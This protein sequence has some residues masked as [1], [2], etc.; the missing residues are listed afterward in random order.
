MAATSTTNNSVKAFVARLGRDYPDF[1][2]TA[3]QQEHWSPKTQTITFN[4]SQPVQKLKFGLLHELAHAL[5]GH[6]NY[7]SDF[8]LLKLESRAW[9]LAAKIGKKYN[10]HIDDAH[11]QRCLNTYRDWL[12]ARSAC[13]A[14]GVHSLQQ[15]AHTY[16][17][18][19]CQTNWRVSS[20]RF[21]RAYRKT[22]K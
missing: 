6:E 8:E 22:I 19:N 18:F 11:V 12:Y 17:C 3:G 9:Q 15:D 13:P 1:E 4:P 7:R 21:V 2:F 10:I 14:C 5:L 20:D 16:H